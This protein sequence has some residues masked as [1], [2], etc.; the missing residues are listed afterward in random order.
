MKNILFIICSVMIFFA[1]SCK[2]SELS[3][4]SVLYY[5]NSFTP[6]GDGI[7]DHWKPYG[8][9][10]LG[11][12]YSM[13]IYSKKDKFL[14]ESNDCLIGWDGKVNGVLCPI[15]YNYYAVKYE[16]LEGVKHSDAGMFQLIK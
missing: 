4:G 10:I 11:G 2:K 14:F 1:S 15:D 6:D 8:F 12:S 16:T 13:K 5:P 7:N 3:S 9:D